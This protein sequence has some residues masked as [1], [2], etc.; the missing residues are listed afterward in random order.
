VRPGAAPPETLTTGPYL[1]TDDG[2]RLAHILDRKGAQTRDAGIAWV[3]AEDIGGIHPLSAFTGMAIEDKLGA[4]ADLAGP[5]LAD[6]PHLA[7]IAWSA[8]QWCS[9]TPADAQARNLAGT[10]LQRALPVERLRQTVIINR[11]LI[12]PEQTAR[13]IQISDAEARWQDWALTRLG[14]PGGVNAL[15]TQPPFPPKSRLWLPRS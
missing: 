4:L 7:G 14:I 5:V 10:A 9:P 6:R 15:L 2:A 12:L 3:W 8:A 11:R 1:E 13:I